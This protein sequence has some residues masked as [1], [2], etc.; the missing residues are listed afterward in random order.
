MCIQIRANQ[1]YAYSSLYALTMFFF[2]T[3]FCFIFSLHFI[4]FPSSFLLHLFCP[5]FFTSSFSL[6]L[7]RFIFFRSFHLSAF[8]VSLLICTE[9]TPTDFPNFQVETGSFFLHFYFPLE[10]LF[11]ALPNYFAF[12]LMIANYLIY[13]RV[14]YATNTPRG[15]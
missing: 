7:F 6:H 13:R 1:V 8:A 11:L 15:R 5:I 14:V 2:L 12:Y 9:R 10:N 3:F 4:F